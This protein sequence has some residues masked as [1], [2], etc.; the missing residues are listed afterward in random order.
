[1]KFGKQTVMRDAVEAF[2]NVGVQDVLVVAV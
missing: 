2:L 1:M